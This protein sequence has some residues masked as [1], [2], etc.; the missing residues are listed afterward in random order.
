LKTR[1][2]LILLTVGLLA[3]RTFVHHSSADTPNKPG[4]V[5][6]A[7]VLSEASGGENWLV[8][9]GSFNQQQFSTLKQINDKNV[10][11]LGLAWWT[12]IDSP[13][14]LASEPIVVD[15]VIYLSAPESR[16]YA[17]EANTGRIR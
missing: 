12:E 5:T 11:G 14:G 7:R 4:D 10:N 2:I 8:K 1:G 13:M 3:G 9:G 17:I 15:G 6:E 16:V